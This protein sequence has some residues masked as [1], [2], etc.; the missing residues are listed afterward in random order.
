MTHIK[1]FEN[2]LI[3]EA[4]TPEASEAQLDAVAKQLG[5]QFADK[6]P[7]DFNRT[8]A[9]QSIKANVPTELA[10]LFGEGGSMASM[11]E[12]GITP[13]KISKKVQEY[14]IAFFNERVPKGQNL[15]T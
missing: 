9:R 2:F 3:S 6:L 5:K 11:R 10:R 1:T 8:Y 15:D 4:K 7:A 12:K 13:R 14:A